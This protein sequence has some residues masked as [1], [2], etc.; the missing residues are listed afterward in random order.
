MNQP[1]KRKPGRPRKHPLPSDAMSSLAA[2]TLRDPDADEDTKSLAGALLTMDDVRGPNHADDTPG[3]ERQAT[4]SAPAEE[5]TRGEATGVSGANAGTEDAVPSTAIDRGGVENDLDC[6]LLEGLNH[7]QAEEH[8]V[9][10]EAERE[11]SRAIQ[12]GSADAEIGGPVVSADGPAVGDGEDEPIARR[13]G[14]IQGHELAAMK[15][16]AW[17]AFD[18]QEGRGKMDTLGRIWGFEP[19]TRNNNTV[20]TFSLRRPG[21]SR[22]ERSI[23]TA[24]YGIDG[25]REMSDALVDEMNGWPV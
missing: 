19:E 17:D 4:G 23:S 6:S 2:K 22:E 10:N 15:A 3:E 24:Q 1:M 25:A 11:D 16:E 7:D 12:F 5:V 20:V 14:G 21:G 13:E 8:A 18:S 9:A